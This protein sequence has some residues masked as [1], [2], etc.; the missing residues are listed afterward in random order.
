MFSYPENDCE[1]LNDHDRNEG[2]CLFFLLDAKG[3]YI[4]DNL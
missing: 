4:F 3:Q 2:I 1:Y